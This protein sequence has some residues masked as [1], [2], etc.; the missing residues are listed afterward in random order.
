MKVTSKSFT[1]GFKFIWIIKKKKIIIKN[2][3]TKKVKQ[4]FEKSETI[5]KNKINLPDTKYAIV[6]VGHH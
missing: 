2:I 1:V 6:S 5:Q 4:K 3:I